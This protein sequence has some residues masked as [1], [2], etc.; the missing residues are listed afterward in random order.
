MGA[1]AGCAVGN[2]CHAVSVHDAVITRPVSRQPQSRKPQPSLQNFVFVAFGASGDYVLWVD[3]RGRVLR[4][5]DDMLA[6]AIGANGRF[7]DAFRPRLS[8]NAPA[9]FLVNLLV[10]LTASFR[11]LG[12][13]N[14]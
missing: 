7:L 12:S 8:V 13:G 4:A 1:V 6:V 11:K 14:F 10:T 9:P 5:S 2:F 3:E